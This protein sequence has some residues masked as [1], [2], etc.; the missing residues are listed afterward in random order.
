M[1]ET[2]ELESF[3]SKLFTG[4]ASH[5]LRGETGTCQGVFSVSRFPHS[6][7]VLSHSRTGCHFTV[8][9]K[10]RD[11]SEASGLEGAEGP[12]CTAILVQ[13]GERSGSSFQ[14]GGEVTFP[15]QRFKLI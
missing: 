6:L 12:G 10:A 15:S 9:T 7:H 4:E 3:P 11:D 14:F 5:W 8:H 2:A 1:G 13:L